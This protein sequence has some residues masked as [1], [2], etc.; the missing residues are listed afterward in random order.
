MN[1][2][3]I[4]IVLFLV[5]VPAVVT[6]FLLDNSGRHEAGF[7]RQ[8]G[9]TVRGVV[10]DEDGR[11]L[12]EASVSVFAITKDAPP[13]PLGDVRTKNDG[14]YE[15]TLPPVEGRYELRVSASEH[16]EVRLPLSTTVPADAPA[17]ALVQDVQLKL[18]ALLTVEIQRANGR[19]V[20]AG[21]YELSSMPGGGLFTGFG[22]QPVVREGRFETGV[23]TIDSLPP[24]QVRLYVALASG[25]TVESLLLL[26][27]G[28]NRHRVDL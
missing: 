7:G 15:L 1:N 19:P 23:F 8:P 13:R 20:G 11:A 18:G 9:G 25:E 2:R 3:L 27:A 22:G 16:Q 17:A 6:L 10:R 21:R 24:A 14:G 4:L 28:K 5:G 26:E 12:W